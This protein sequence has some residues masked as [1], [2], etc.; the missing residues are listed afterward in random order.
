MVEG[1]LFSSSLFLLPRS[2]MSVE[3]EIYECQ[4]NEVWINVILLIEFSP[5]SLSI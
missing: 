3:I 2:G 4:L 1:N 5:C